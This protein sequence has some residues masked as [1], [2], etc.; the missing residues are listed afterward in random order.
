M[1]SLANTQLGH[2][3]LLRMIGSGGMGE[4]YLAEDT[5]I[6]RQ[7]AIKVVNVEM[8][9]YP[10]SE[11][12]KTASRL[13]EREMKA[14]SALDHPHILPLFEFGEEQVQDQRL[15]YMVMPFRPEGS[16]TGWLRQRQR[17]LLPQEVAILIAQAADA[18]QHAHDRHIIHQDVKPSNFLIR[19]RSGPPGVLPDLVLADFGISKLTN[20]SSQTTH[21]VRGTAAYMPPEQWQGDPVPASDQ[22]ALAVMAYQLLTGRLPFQGHSVQVMRQHLEVPPPPLHTFNANITPALEAVIQ[23]A[24][25]KQSASRFE[26][27]TAFA[28]AFQQALTY[29]DMRASVTITSDEARTGTSRILS[30]HETQPLFVT[31]PAG[32]YDDQVLRLDEKGEPYYEGGPTGPLLLT[33]NVATTYAPPPV[34]PVGPGQSGPFYAVTPPPPPPP[35]SSLLISPAQPWLSGLLPREGKLPMN[36]RGLLVAS[37]GL[38]ILVVLGSFLTYRLVG[39]SAK[40]APIAPPSVGTPNATATLIAQNPDPY[41]SHYKTLAINDPLTKPAWWTD[42][43][44]N[45]A[46]EI[47]SFSA[48]GF[49]IN[50]V[51]SNMFYYCGAS[52]ANFS[53]FDMQ[54]QMSILKGNCGSVLFRGDFTNAR[55]YLYRVCADGAYSLA[56]YKDNQGSDA[57]NIRL[58]N[59][60]AIKT[61]LNQ[62]NT[63]GLAVRGNRFD[64]YVNQAYLGSASDDNLDAGEF[65]LAASDTNDPTEVLFTKVRVWTPNNSNSPAFNTGLTAT[66]IAA[67]PDP[68]PP[69][70]WKLAVDDPLSQPVWWSDRKIT[71]ASCQFT[72]NAYHVIETGTRK[73]FNCNSSADNF[74]NFAFQ[75]QMQILQGDCGAVAFRG[76]FPD[77]KTYFFN[78]CQS[79][80]YDLYLYK[81]PAAKDSQTVRY[82]S[83]GFINSGLK[84]SNI[85]G[86]VADGATIGLY[87]NDHQIASISDNTYSSGRFAL[88]ANEYNS[89]ITEVV[90]KD[91]K[92]WSK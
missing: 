33:V 89:S 57:I 67:N 88:I 84:Q 32:A 7:V 14:I 23:R 80:T 86:I 20:S 90:Y 41:P 48:D 91:V 45:T 26:S 30:L 76:S 25:A 6:G 87:I 3:K 11:S 8:Q 54:V 74:S 65:A 17:V 31:I 62:T 22:Y 64:L 60:D 46:G 13:F 63:L 66:A 34:V 10:G 37:I 71:T 83:T 15:T 70:N 59:A 5:R 36:R 1:M 27:I 68:Y 82:G 81:G 24:L 58:G 77:F 52:T 47:C 75:V 19:A 39:A 78:V 56:Y 38:V 79:G 50:E 40:K 21:A 44:G 2:Y 53:D 55:Y 35:A 69:A 85:L 61:G 12:A 4:V 43:T 16:L 28:Q 51:T 73:Y 9:D 18:L 29:R 42:Q 49:H 72:G 92:I